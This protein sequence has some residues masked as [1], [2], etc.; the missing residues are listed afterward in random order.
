MNLSQ[1]KTCLTV[2]LA[3]KQTSKTV[4]WHSQNHTSSD[5]T[6]VVHRLKF[7]QSA[8]IIFFFLN[9]RI[10]QL[11]RGTFLHIT[12]KKQATACTECVPYFKNWT[13]NISTERW[14]WCPMLWQMQES[15]LQKTKHVHVASYTLKQFDLLIGPNEIIMLHNFPQ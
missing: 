8:I 15:M 10:T 12:I 5:N 4:L 11:Y 13:I 2:S 14:K 6:I 3:T 7:K 1:N 9:T